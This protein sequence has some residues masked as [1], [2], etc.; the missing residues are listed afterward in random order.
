MLQNSLLVVDE[1]KSFPMQY[2]SG[3]MRM[4][5]AGMIDRF[6]SANPGDVSGAIAE[7]YDYY[8]AIWSDLMDAAGVSN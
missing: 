4:C 2:V 5:R 6:G 1:A 7:E 8:S 3:G